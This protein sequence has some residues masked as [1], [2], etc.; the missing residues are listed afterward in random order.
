M[1]KRLTIAD[2]IDMD[3]S[4]IGQKDIDKLAKQ[5]AKKATDRIRSFSNKKNKNV[6][7]PAVNKIKE[8]YKEGIPNPDE[9]TFQQKQKLIYNIQDFF[10]S[11]TS[12][13][14]EAR[15]VAREQDS[16]LFGEDVFGQP[17]YR[18]SK[19]QRDSF[20]SAFDEFLNQNPTLH[21]DSE[22][23]L[24]VLADMVE[25]GTI[26]R[27]G[28]F[29]NLFGKIAVLNEMR[30]RVDKAGEEDGGESGYKIFTIDGVDF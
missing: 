18:M 16:R 20:W 4:K 27:K 17:K 5:F 11:R 8:K 6:Y 21:D 9:M 22:V 23:V 19:A 7:S 14:S 24:Q 2:I 12:D 26:S 1:A 3:L 28:N 10:R 29:K 15:R 13:V 30:K 25:D